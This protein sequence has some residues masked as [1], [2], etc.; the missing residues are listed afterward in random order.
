MI[1]TAL[2]YACFYNI[3]ET[4]LLNSDESYGKRRATVYPTHLSRDLS[5]TENPLAKWGFFSAELT[6]AEICMF[7]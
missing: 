7:T 4:R 2:G 6:N 3:H 1:K 5:K